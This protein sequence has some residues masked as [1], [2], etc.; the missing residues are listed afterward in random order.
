MKDLGGK[1][2]KQHLI[3][4]WLMSMVSL[5]QVLQVPSENWIIVV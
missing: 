2:K 1:I 5:P 3:V 4:A